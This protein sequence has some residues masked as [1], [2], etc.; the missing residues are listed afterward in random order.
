MDVQKIDSLLRKR[1][2]CTIPT[3]C[4]ADVTRD[5]VEHLRQVFEINKR[6]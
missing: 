5:A 2:Y 3:K 6:V 4:S 1:T